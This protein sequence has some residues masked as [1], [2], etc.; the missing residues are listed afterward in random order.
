MADYG[1]IAV[2]T[3]PAVGIRTASEHVAVNLPLTWGPISKTTKVMPAPRGMLDYRIA[4]T[5]KP[6]VIPVVGQLWPRTKT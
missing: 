1:P 3:K 6:A 5:Q 2:S 4:G